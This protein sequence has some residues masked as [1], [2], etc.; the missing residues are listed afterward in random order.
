LHILEKELL[1]AEI[2]ASGINH[3]LSII[4]SQINTREV[5]VKSLKSIRLIGGFSD[6]ALIKILKLGN[7]SEIVLSL[8]LENF[9][10]FFKVSSLKSEV[11]IDIALLCVILV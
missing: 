2:V 4:D 5:I 11:S 7:L 1:V 6:A 9:D 10:L 3:L 8:E